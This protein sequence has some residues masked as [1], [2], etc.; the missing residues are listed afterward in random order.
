MTTLRLFTTYYYES[1]TPTTATYDYLP[2][3][4]PYEYR[5]PNNEYDCGCSY[6]RHRRRRRR[7]CR[8]CHC[9]CCFYQYYT[10]TLLLHYYT[11]YEKDNDNYGLL[12]HEEA[13][14][15]GGGDARVRL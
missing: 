1:T 14:K 5:L 13:L 15:L 7:R 12:E 8:R 10:T 6:R 9:C 4:L 3:R 2:L 11:L